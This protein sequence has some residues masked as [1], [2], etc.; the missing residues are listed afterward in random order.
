MRLSAWGRPECAPVVRRDCHS[1]TGCLRNRHLL[2]LDV[3]GLGPTLHATKTLVRWLG[4]TRNRAACPALHGID[5]SRPRGLVWHPDDL[6]TVF[7]P[8]LSLLLHPGQDMISNPR[9]KSAWFA[10]NPSVSR[11]RAGQRSGSSFIRASRKHEAS[12]M[13]LWGKRR[14][15][16]LSLGKRGGW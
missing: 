15:R 2:R 7:H 1:T 5:W 6:L 8:A 10:R 9:N 3:H 11:A 12:P 13:R 16:A 14:P 4:N